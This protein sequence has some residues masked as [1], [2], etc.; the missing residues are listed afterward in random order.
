LDALF[1]TESLI[2]YQVESTP[3]HGAAANLINHLCPNLLLKFHSEVLKHP[4]PQKPIPKIMLLSGVCNASNV[5]DHDCG[6]INLLSSIHEI[7]E[8]LIHGIS[9]ISPLAPRYDVLDDELE[10]ELVEWCHV[11]FLH[12]LGCF[13]PWLLTQSLGQ[14]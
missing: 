2:L 13:E 3:H 12:C 10:Q 5:P 1:G 8:T 9:L 7:R 6:E 4:G 14:L 11:P